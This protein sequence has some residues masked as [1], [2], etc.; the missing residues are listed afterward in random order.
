MGRALAGMLAIAVGSIITTAGC[1]A[2]K[3][4]ESFCAVYAS[5]KSSYLTQNGDA[6]KAIEG[7]DDAG[8]AGLKSLLAL[9]TA[10][11]DIVVMMDK[12]AQAAPDEIEPDIR[13]I[14]DQLQKQMENAGDNLDNPLAGL[15]SALSSG[16]L[17]AGSWQRF[18][19]YV[20]NNCGG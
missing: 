20:K 15:G 13:N 9:G 5:E 14:H 8:A 12:L 18:D 7:E 17:T 3:T 1:S 6:L 11:G 19:S 10:M 4:P 2:P 16:L